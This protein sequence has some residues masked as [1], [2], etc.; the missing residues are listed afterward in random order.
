[1]I[2]TIEKKSAKRKSK[3]NT[4][5]DE[6]SN[7]IYSGVYSERI[8]GINQLGKELNVNPLTVNKV[9]KDMENNG[10]IKRYERIGTFVTRKRRVGLLIYFSEHQGNHFLNS[11]SIFHNIIDGMSSALEKEYY[12]LQACIAAPRHVDFINQL[13]REVDGLVI[14]RSGTI[15]DEDFEIFS[16]IP[17]VL[18]MGEYN[19]ALN[20]SMITYNNDVIGRMAADYL[21]EQNCREFI[22]YGFKGG[23]LFACRWEGFTGRLSGRGF[24]ANSVFINPYQQTAR[25]VFH[26]SCRQLKPF[27]TKSRID[28]LG[29]FLPADLSCHLLYQILYKFGGSPERTK[30]ICCDN[31]SF[32]LHGLYPYPVSIDIRMKDIGQK[33]VECLLRNIGSEGK[34]EKEQVILMP[35]LVFPDDHHSLA[36]WRLSE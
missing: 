36:G 14:V 8:P 9:L 22:F 13:K 30:V 10:L 24:T 20:T 19:S 34:Q 3:Y 12:S 31:N 17:W 35:E 1:M 6:I 5:Y 2:T 25:D 18:A 11:S 4:V 16:D 23:P 15:R 27:M 33:A 28:Q 32:N 26:D 21:L 29:I 7:R